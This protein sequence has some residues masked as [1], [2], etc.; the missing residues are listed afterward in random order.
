MRF[1]ALEV[2]IELAGI[3]RRPAEA[4][5]RKG[6]TLYRHLREATNSIALN[7]GEG[8]GRSGA[9]RVHHFRIAAGSAEEVRTALR[10]AVAWGDLEPKAVQPALDG[11]DRVVGL[12][13]GLTH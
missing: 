9:D 10:L 8:R 1:L 12:L 6:P 13:W 3:V 4:I 11:V 2:A 5:R 7:I